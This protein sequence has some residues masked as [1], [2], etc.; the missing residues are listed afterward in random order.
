MSKQAKT[1]TCVICRD[2][3]DKQ[4]LLRFVVSPNNDIML[5]V[6]HKAPAR[7]TYVC[8]KATCLDKAINKSVIVKMLKANKTENL[9]A[10][11]EKSLTSKISSNIVMLKKSQMLTLGT[12]NVVDLL[13]AN[14]LKYVMIAGDVSAKTA[15]KINHYAQKNSVKSDALFTKDILSDITGV[16]NC[17]VIGLKPCALTTSLVTTLNFYKKVLN[18]WKNLKKV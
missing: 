14:K 18:T 15:E 17:T 12:D 16:A 13:K 7:G 10:D 9:M 11:M 3:F 5:D 4:D 6:Y 1:R 2:N 8:D